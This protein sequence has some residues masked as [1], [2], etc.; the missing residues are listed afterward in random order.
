M[1]AEIL[2]V[3]SE[4]LPGEDAAGCL[5]F[6]ER[7]LAVYGLDP[8]THTAVGGESR[9]TDALS[10]ALSRCDLVFVV[11]GLGV[12]TGCATLLAVSDMLNLPLELHE[13]T[14]QRVEEYGRAAGREPS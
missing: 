9:L 7:E 8:L 1:N 11:G 13:P 3:E 12:S 4:N 5:Q 2:T 10:Q 6:L 14:R